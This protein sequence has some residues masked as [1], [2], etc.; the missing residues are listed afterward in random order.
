MKDKR[1]PTLLGILIILGLI[2]SLTLVKKG[3]FFFSR[4]RKNSAPQEVKVTNVTENS[5]V[6]S[7]VTKG[8]VPGLVKLVG[9]GQEKAIPDYRDQPGQLNK[10]DTH[11]VLADDLDSDT[12]YKFLVNSGGRDFYQK[13][14]TPYTTKTALAVPGEPPKANLASGKVVTFDEKP[15]QGAIVY[16]DIPNISPLSAL[17]TSQGNWVVSLAQAYR[18]DLIGRAN[19]QEGRVI[20]KIKAEGGQMG[21][22]TA[23][24]FTKND[25]PVPV[26]KLGQDVDF[27]RKEEDLL[28]EDKSPT[29][30]QSSKLEDEGFY[31]RE[32]KDF[33][34]ISP[35]DGETITIPRPEIFGQGPQGGKVEINLESSVVHQAEIE[36]G[37]DG[38]WQWSPP[39]DLS[40][41]AHTLNVNYTNPE[42]GE[43]ETYVRTFVLAATADDSGPAFSA[44]PSGTTATPTLTPSPTTQPT[45]TPLPTNTLQP[46]STPQPTASIVPT[47]PPRKSQPSTESGVPDSGFW[48]PAFILLGGSAILFLSLAWL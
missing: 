21:T 26:I 4:A 6:V 5:F 19:Y 14:Q 29:P 27:T 47:S 30:T 42:T 20:E 24:V 10:Y 34:I 48:E 40:P 28:A 45:N 37:P 46:T 18:K 35:E 44:T 2:S 16:L 25:D 39:Q 38:E 43:K 12:E 41:G 31:L 32:K 13:G 17:V 9:P 7:W 1:I 23:K 33:K 11:Y 22:A 15:A 8:K 36:I 3:T